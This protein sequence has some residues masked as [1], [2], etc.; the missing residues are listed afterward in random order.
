VIVK[1]RTG[2]MN[3][4]VATMI[5]SHI[6]ASRVPLLADTHPTAPHRAKSL[7]SL[8]VQSLTVLDSLV[9]ATVPRIMS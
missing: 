9:N 2:A 4:C 5:V 1:A 8:D 6:R 3:T 7:S